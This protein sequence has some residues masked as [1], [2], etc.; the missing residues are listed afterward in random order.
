MTKK[1]NHSHTWTPDREL[2]HIRVTLESLLREILG[3]PY[4]P[5]REPACPFP[6]T[7]S[8]VEEFLQNIASTAE[9]FERIDQQVKK[10]ARQSSTGCHPRETREA[11]EPESQ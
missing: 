8:E 4:A 6:A 11:P 3:L 7:P 2:S 9:R 5:W 1:R 10:R